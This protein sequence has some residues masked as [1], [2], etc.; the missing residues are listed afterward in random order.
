MPTTST[1]RARVDEFV[2]NL[3]DLIR[4]SA[5]ESVREALDGA[6]APARRGPGRPRKKATKRKATRRKASGPRKAARRKTA[7]KRVRR[8]PEDLEATANSILSYIKANPGSNSEELG[9]A[10]GMTATEMRPPIHAMIAAG[11]LKATG[12]A[13]GTRYAAGGGARRKAGKR[14]TAS[15]RRTAKRKLAR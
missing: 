5:L 10:L 6:A 13:R 8:S 14:K 3:S 12:K 1:L 9:K 15:N 7:G 4:E 2:A 11:T